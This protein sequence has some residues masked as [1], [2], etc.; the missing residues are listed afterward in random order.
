MSDTPRADVIKVRDGAAVWRQVDDET[1]L[2][3]LDSSM[4]LGLNHTGTEVWPMMVNGATREELVERL[5]SLFG[6]DAERA[7]A[8]IDAFVAACDEHDLLVTQ[9]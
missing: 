4:Y 8:D 9:G 5:V 2:L 7:A 6:I 3:A 1:M